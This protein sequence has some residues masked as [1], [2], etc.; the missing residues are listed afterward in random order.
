[1]LSIPAKAVEVLKQATVDT[2]RKTS[3]VGMISQEWLTL[4]WILYSL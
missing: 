1:M 2:W 4:F 3:S